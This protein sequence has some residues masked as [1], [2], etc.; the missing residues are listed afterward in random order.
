MS[1]VAVIVAKLKAHAPL[2]AVVEARN[3]MAGPLPQGARLPSIS[4]TLVTGSELTMVKQPAV[5]MRT[6]MVR[7]SVL[8]AGQQT[9][10]ADTGYAGLREIME[11]V[12][13]ACPKTRGTVASINVDSITPAGIGPDLPTEN[14]STLSSSRDYFVRWTA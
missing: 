2:V 3:I 4:V 1:A 11:L 8:V 7:V 13:S 5:A 9:S 10:N 14:P 12:R 6:E